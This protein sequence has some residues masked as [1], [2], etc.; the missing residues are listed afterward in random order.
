M[1]NLLTP[2]V[3]SF[4]GGIVGGAA[5][6]FAG[7]LI[8]GTTRVQ[9]SIAQAIRKHEDECRLVTAIR[10]PLPERIRE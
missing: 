10:T 6:G 5:G 4:I 8:A 9:A 3:L 2:D 1:S 7:G